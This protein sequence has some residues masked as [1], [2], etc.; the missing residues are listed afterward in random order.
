[1]NPELQAVIA[2]AG[3]SGLFSGMTVS[4]FVMVRFPMR[5]IGVL[6]APSVMDV[7]AFRI[8]AVPFLTMKGFV[9]SAP[10]MVPLPI[11]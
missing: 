9:L 7:P 8:S 2:K 3:T 4:E 10:E 6:D 5:D 11:S 1:M